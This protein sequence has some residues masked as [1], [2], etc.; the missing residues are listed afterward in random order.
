MYNNAKICQN[1]QIFGPKIVRKNYKNHSMF[2]PNI[3]HDPSPHFRW[4]LIVRQDRENVP[5][6]PY[7]HLLSYQNTP[8]EFIM[9]LFQTETRDSKQESCSLFIQIYVFISCST[10]PKQEKMEGA[11]YE[12]VK[13][14]RADQG[15]KCLMFSSF[16]L[17]EQR[18]KRRIWK[19]HKVWALY[20]DLGQPN[21][22]KASLISPKSERTLSRDSKEF[23]HIPNMT[24]CIFQLCVPELKGTNFFL[25]NNHNNYIEKEA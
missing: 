5:T 19:M 1:Q 23:S 20:R 17:Q 6:T 24:W 2:S 10:A 22:S 9:S 15:A 14:A 7:P 25:N 11:E 8:L 21:P 3:G 16:Q 4:Y 18:A 13:I 12:C